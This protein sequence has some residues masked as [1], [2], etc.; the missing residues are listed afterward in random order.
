MGHDDKLRQ[1]SKIKGE[2]LTSFF[3]SRNPFNLPS[4]SQRILL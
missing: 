1:H 4:F 2:M 3:R